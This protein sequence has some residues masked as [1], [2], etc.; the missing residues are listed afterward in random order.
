MAPTVVA[1]VFL[2]TDNGRWDGEEPNPGHQQQHND[3]EDLVLKNER[4]KLNHKQVE[5]KTKRTAL[6]TL[7]KMMYYW[8]YLPTKWK[9]KGIVDAANEPKNQSAGS[10]LKK[11]HISQ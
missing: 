3:T 10:I 9:S 6:V 7:L 4:N 1:T 8:L 2:R 11:V 5:L